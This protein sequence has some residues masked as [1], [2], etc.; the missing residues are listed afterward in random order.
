MGRSRSVSE[1]VTHKHT[2]ENRMALPICLR[3][4]EKSVESAQQNAETGNRSRSVA[5]GVTQMFSFGD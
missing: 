3:H 4:L 1:G 5:A 2:S